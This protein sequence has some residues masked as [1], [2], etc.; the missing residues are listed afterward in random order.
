MKSKIYVLAVALAALFSLTVG[1]LLVAQADSNPTAAHWNDVQMQL[2]SSSSLDGAT[3][4]AEDTPVS[5]F[6]A[7]PV[8]ISDA[9]PDS[10]VA[11]AAQVDAVVA[12]VADDHGV[13]VERFVTD[14]QTPETKRVAYLY[15]PAG[16]HE[17]R[18]LQS[19][20]PDFA[21]GLMKTQA[22]PLADSEMMNATD[23]YTITG[24]SLAARKAAALDL[25]NGL[26]P[27]G[28]GVAAWRVNLITFAFGEPPQLFVA[29][30]LA[31]LMC[32]L[33]AALATLLDAQ[34]YAVLVLHGYG[35]GRMW[36]RD[37]A[38]NC[39]AS[40][41]A[42]LAVCAV[43]AFVC[44]RVNGFAQWTRF[45]AVSGALLLVFALAIALFHIGC[46][47]L[48]ASQPLVRGLKGAIPLGRA[49]LD[50]YIIRVPAALVAMTTVSALMVAGA[51]IGKART[52]LDYWG[53][54]GNI[55]Y[56]E[57]MRGSATAEQEGQSNKWM[58]DQIAAGEVIR[59]YE[60]SLSDM[61]VSSDATADSASDST[62]KLSANG[63]VLITN[64]QYLQ[65]QTVKDAAGNRIS[66]VPTGTVLVMVPQEREAETNDIAAVVKSY[67][68]KHWEQTQLVN[69][70]GYDDYFNHEDDTTF[71]SQP[72]PTVT[73]ITAAAG[74]KL[75][76]YRF[77]G[78]AGSTSS[79]VGTADSTA[80]LLDSPI[81]VAMDASAGVDNEM[82]YSTEWMSLFLIDQD[83]AWASLKAAGLDTAITCMRS[84]TDSIRASAA[85]YQRDLYQAAAAFLLS[86][87]V[88]VASGIALARTHVRGRA[89]AVFAK[90]IHGWSFWSIHRW[91]IVCEMV[92]FGLIAVNGVA[93]YRLLARTYD[94]ITRS[95]AFNP[96]MSAVEVAVICVLS[97]AVCLIAAARYTHALCSRPHD[98]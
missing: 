66:T 59:S 17:A 89:Q 44:W 47:R 49:T 18:W 80:S 77:D 63:V 39:R 74:Q 51:G 83:A 81:I 31:L 1:F 96:A 90:Y 52:Q 98:H 3:D 82:D 43:A 88:L 72:G 13:T 76:D 2:V 11:T 73:V 58:A 10:T 5:A 30:A 48:C 78:N 54:N 38:Q 67:L 94:P 16:S 22:R 28:Y 79:G 56:I 41:V 29:T 7:S 97:V 15:A 50:M 61:K 87:L 35:T 46:L 55:A 93:H 25:A 70:Y 85:R 75:F 6:G 40:L 84:P 34:G 53:D 21:P 42:I 68:H 60:T 95:Y 8:V 19:G 37:I 26:A 45:L 12:R 23:T 69:K 33:L 65:R 71:A 27:L 20:Y 14:P 4:L 24:A 62:A 57:G 9:M 92:L 86:V 64:T 36:R 91:L 32:A